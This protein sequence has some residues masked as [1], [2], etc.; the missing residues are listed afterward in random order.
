MIMRYSIC[1]RYGGGIMAITLDYVHNEL[2]KLLCIIDDICSQNG[3]CYFL[4]GGSEIGA[5]REKDFIPWDDDVDIKMPRKD[6]ERFRGI[7]KKAL[8]QGY[9]YIEASDFSPH[10]YDFVSRVIKNDVLTRKE[11]DE[12]RFYGNLENR[13]SI[14]IFVLDPICDDLFRQKLH[15]FR[16]KA[17]YGMAMSKRYD[18][19]KEQ[20]TRVQ[21]IMIAVL[22]GIGSFFSAEQL[23]KMQ[24]KLARKYENQA[25]NHVVFANSPLYALFAVPS[26]WYDGTT[27]MPIRDRKFPVPAGYDQELTT[28]YGDYMHPPEDK[29]KYKRHVDVD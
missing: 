1:L 11:T 14:D 29:S 10:F 3:I 23:I 5:I 13:I 22:R 4:D 15:L 24:E 8:P 6:Y 26:S 25:T 27:L 20:Y 16:L 7:V 9:N 18:I 19:K 17:V 12:D 28:F 21:R 2:F